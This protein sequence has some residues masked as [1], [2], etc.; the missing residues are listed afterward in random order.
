M[1]AVSFLET[2]NLVGLG[3]SADR[4][5]RYKVYKNWGKIKINIFS[6]HVT[7]LNATKLIEPAK[8]QTGLKI[9][10]DVVDGS[11]R[12]FDGLGKFWQR[13][14]HELENNK[15][16]SG[17]VDRVRKVSDAAQPMIK[18]GLSELKEMTTSNKPSSIHSDSSSLPSFMEGRL[19]KNKVS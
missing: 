1:A 6:S 2:T 10:S 14:T 7:D 3:L 12:V 17:I 16:V 18:E 13:N 4:V 15:T 9:V 19:N 5:Y 8:Q 11:Y